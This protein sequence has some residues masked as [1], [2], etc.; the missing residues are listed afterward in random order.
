MA[1]SAVQDL[2]AKGVALVQAGDMAGAEAS[3]KACIAADAK[4]AIATLNLGIL[5]TN[6]RAF[7]EAEPVLRQAA[8]LQPTIDSVTAFAN[9]LAATGRTPA[10]EQ[11]FRDI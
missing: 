6:R 5:L 2:F 1:Q 11:C 3:F 9:L 8:A 10:A 7:A 4:H